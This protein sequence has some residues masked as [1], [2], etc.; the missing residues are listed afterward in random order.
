MPQIEA[1]D[2]DHSPAMKT[3]FEGVAERLVVRHGKSRDE[4]RVLVDRFFSLDVD[5]LECAF[6]MH[7]DPD[8]LAEDLA[9]L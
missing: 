9:R 8:T 2:L 6:L 3:Y 4:A 5:P 1:R 7:D